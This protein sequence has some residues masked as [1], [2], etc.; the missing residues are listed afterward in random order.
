MPVAPDLSR[1]EDLTPTQLGAVSPVEC[2][3]A[4]NGLRVH[5]TSRGGT[6]PFTD[7]GGLVTRLNSACW[8]IHDAAFNGDGASFPIGNCWLRPDRRISKGTE[9]G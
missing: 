2:L 5:T 4:A 3:C 8:V 6:R 1:D 9:A 7:K